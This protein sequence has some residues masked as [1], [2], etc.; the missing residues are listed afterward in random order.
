[1]YSNTQFCHVSLHDGKLLSSVLIIAQ[2][3]QLSLLHFKF[4]NIISVAWN[5]WP[6]V[7]RYNNLL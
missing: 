3:L 1:M 5:L 2:N 7:H 6:T 4:P